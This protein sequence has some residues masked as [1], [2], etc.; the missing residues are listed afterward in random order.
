MQSKEI[1]SIVVLKN[2]LA[3]NVYTSDLTKDRG[4]A[5]CQV[6]QNPTS[7]PATPRELFP[8]GNENPEAIVWGHGL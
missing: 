1:V 3:I 5:L 2:D 7:A 8:R 6:L 4:E